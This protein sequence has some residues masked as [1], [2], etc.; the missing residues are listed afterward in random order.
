MRGN[1]FMH[2]IHIENNGPIDQFEMDINEFNLLIGEQATGKST[3][4]KSVY[5]F[6]AIKTVIVDYLTQLYDSNSYNNIPQDGVV[7][8]KAIRHDLKATFIRLFGYSWDLNPALN[9]RYNYAEDIWAEIALDNYEDT[10]KSFIAIEYSDNLKK[11]ILE[12][13]NDVRDMRRNRTHVVLS[14]ALAGEEK[15]RDYNTIL[16]RVNEIFRDDKEI[17]YI[18]AGRSLLTVLSSSRAAMN[19][20]Q[21]LDLVTERFMMMIDSVREIYNR[22]VKKAHLYYPKPNRRF[23]PNALAEYIVKMQKGEYFYNSGQEELWI[24]DGDENA[25]KINFASSGQQEILWVF[26]FLYALLLREEKTFVII[27]EPEAHIYPTLQKDVMEFIS[28]FTKYGDNEVFITT[29]SPYILTTVNNLYYAGVLADEGHE[30]QIRKLLENKSMI[31]K[32]KLSA[33]KILGKEQ[34]DADKRIV[35]LLQE[36]G[37]EIKTELIDDV[38]AQINELYTSLYDI[39]LGNE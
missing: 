33:Y 20:L 6:R 39:D 37:M 26:N 30:T 18:P 22:G 24:E 31:R 27:E 13:Q 34:A 19:S 38:S 10:G 16:Q 4:A 9:M 23:D 17:Y 14:L 8:F 25:V 36:D 2:R 11:Q 1:D 7:L 32:G 29:H 21:N 15:K 3:I 35:S 12:L 5:F 28:M